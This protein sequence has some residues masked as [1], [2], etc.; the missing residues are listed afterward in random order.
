MLVTTAAAV[1]WA[2][3]IGYQTGAVSA[4]PPQAES[5]DALARQVYQIFTQQCI[6]CHGPAKAGGLDLRT[7]EGLRKGGVSGPVVVPHKT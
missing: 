6:K 2:A 4:A 5:A 7:E 1:S 3:V